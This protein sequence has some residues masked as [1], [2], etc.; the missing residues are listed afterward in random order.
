MIWRR[1]RSVA[2]PEPLA[3]VVLAAGRGARL[4]GVT[5]ALI[6]VEGQTLI[7]RL[8]RDLQAAG[9]SRI[10]VVTGSASRQVCDECR[11]AVREGSV[12]LSFVDALGGG[13]QM[14]S[15][16]LGL[17]ALADACCPVMVCLADLPLLDAKDLVELKVASENRPPGTDMVVPDVQG[18]PGHPLV[19]S[20]ELVQE[21][22]RTDEQLIGKAWRLAHPQRVY[23]WRT[24]REAYI[25]D[26]DTP[27]DVQACRDAGLE[28]SLPSEGANESP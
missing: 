11:A 9:I 4:G 22:L 26:L 2:A 21:W 6:G 15:L 23:R 18:T 17:Q 10:V 7:A 27:Q 25:T 16:H 3:A 8:I 19:L 24:T 5:K 28:L 14:H 20:P 13:D 12:S 1:V